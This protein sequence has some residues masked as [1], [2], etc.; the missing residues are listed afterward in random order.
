LARLSHELRTP[1]NAIMGYAELLRAERDGPLGSAKYRDFAGH[2]LESAA[3]CLTLANDLSDPASLGTALR[4]QEFSEVDV[5][6]A[7]RASLGILAPIALK[8]GVVLADS[9]DAAAPRAILDRRSLRQI[10]LNL[11]ANAVKATPPGGSVT[12]ST[13][14]KPGAGLEIAIA[15]TGPGLTPDHLAEARAG[16]GNGL[17][18]P[19]SR[20]L[21]EA[22]GA[23]L[24]IESAAGLGARVAL[25]IPMGRLVT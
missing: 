19:L 7:V 9:L 22:N 17:G 21:A 5:N 20:Q 18:L 24:R 25:Q 15:D 13:A 11:I 6:E 23:G 1:L 10:L 8:A 3:H 2:I 14:Y 4:P 12:A 16:A